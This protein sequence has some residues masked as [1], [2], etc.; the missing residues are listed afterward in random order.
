MFWYAMKNDVCNCA[1]V[2]AV[3]EGIQ[4]KWSVVVLLLVVAD[5]FHCHYAL[6]LIFGTLFFFKNTF[7]WFLIF[8]E[9]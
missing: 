6:K 8:S 2:L 9:S 7:F 4:K 3:D 5:P 1:P